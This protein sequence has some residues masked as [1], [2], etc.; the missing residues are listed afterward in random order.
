MAWGGEGAQ[1]VPLLAP[2]AGVGGELDIG[3]VGS[4][5]E[6]VLALVPLDKKDNLQAELG[7]LKPREIS[8]VR[9]PDL[10]RKVPALVAFYFRA[11]QSG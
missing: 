7:Y 1:H 3:G 8:P 11:R 4:G 6:A 2:E 5:G 10:G 9:G